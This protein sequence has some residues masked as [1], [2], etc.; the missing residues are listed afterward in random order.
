MTGKDL[1]AVQ[2]VGCAEMAATAAGGISTCSVHG[3]C[4]SALHYVP[5]AGL[6]RESG[7]SPIIDPPSLEEACPRIPIW[8]TF[9]LSCL[10]FGSKWV[11]GAEKHGA[12]SHRMPIMS[13]REA[14]ERTLGLG[15]PENPPP[16]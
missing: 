5:H 16:H 6:L 7:Q 1:L 4:R 11:S 14:Q 12:T 10:N 3:D 13:V 2:K 15:L 8:F 9:R